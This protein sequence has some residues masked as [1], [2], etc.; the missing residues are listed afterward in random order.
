[1]N[2]IEQAT[3][4]FVKY[5]KEW[6]SNASRMENGYEYERSFIEMN[7]KIQRETLEI[8]TGKIPKS[9]NQKKNFTPKVEK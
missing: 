2:T 7:K 3:A 5:Y 4:I 8:S 9:K 1:M 6:E